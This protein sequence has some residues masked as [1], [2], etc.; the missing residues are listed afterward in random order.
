MY[1]RAY[2]KT[3][4]FNVVGPTFAF[5]HTVNVEH[6]SWYANTCNGLVL[7]AARSSLDGV[8][9]NPATK[10]EV[11]LSVPSLPPTQA[12]K[13]DDGYVLR[14][15]LGFGYAPSSKVYKALIWEFTDDGADSTT[16]TLMVVSLDSTGCHQEPRTVFSCDMEMLCEHS[17]HIADG[18]VYF[19]IYTSYF[20]GE[21]GRQVHCIS[22]T[23]VLVFNADDEVATSVALPKGQDDIQPCHMLQVGG[24]PCVYTCKGQDMVLWL[25]T[26]DHQWEKTYTLV[27]QSSRS[28]DYLLGAWDC[29]EGLLFAKF[30]I[31]G[32]YLYN[33]HQAIAGEEEEGGC[34][35]DIRLEAVCSLK[36]ED[37]MPEPL[38]NIG[39]VPTNLLDYHPTLVSPASIFGDVV[40]FSGR[41]ELDGISSKHE[42]DWTLVERTRKLF[43]EPAMQ[44]LSAASGDILSSRTDKCCYRRWQKKGD[45]RWEM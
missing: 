34:D 40:A 35:G 26:P 7:L 8:V 41:C 36:N 39:G 24:R 4:Y 25:L 5:E 20:T 1:T 2:C 15:F 45:G 17:L 13:D 29:G 14:R 9:F 43:V 31:T 22:A 32:A 16:T 33:P 12:P 28:N 38:K 44:M 3:I 27:K 42:L 18:K 10:E 37:E 11:L 30:K 19:L 6:G 21:E 23:S